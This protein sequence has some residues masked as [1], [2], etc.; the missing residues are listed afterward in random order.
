M[1]LMFPIYCSRWSAPVPCIKTDQDNPSLNRALFPTSAVRFL[2][3]LLWDAWPTDT[4]ARLS[5][6]MTQSGFLFWVARGHR[7]DSPSILTWFSWPRYSQTR[8][9]EISVMRG[10]DSDHYTT[11][12]RYPYWCDLHASEPETPLNYCKQ[13]KEYI[14]AEAFQYQQSRVRSSTT[15][16][17]S[18][19]PN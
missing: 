17:T 14:I 9:F 19:R 10:N 18:L 1:L 3:F 12:G 7:S 8:T 16:P 6:Y 13:R 2:S 4:T 15:M 11:A 5:S